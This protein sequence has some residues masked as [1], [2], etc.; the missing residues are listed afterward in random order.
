M[1]TEGSLTGGGRLQESNHK[2]PL[3]RRGP[4]TSTLWKIVYYIQFLSYAMRRSTLL[5]SSL[6]ILKVGSCQASAWKRSHQ[7]CVPQTPNNTKT[8]GRMTC[9]CFLRPI[10]RDLPSSCYISWH[11]HIANIEIRECHKWSL[12][13]G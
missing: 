8:I 6:Y 10:R 2:G 1:Q 7:C 12:T 3:P 4:G 5:L 13:R 11:S 9:H